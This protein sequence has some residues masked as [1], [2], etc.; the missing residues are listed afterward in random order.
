MLIREATKPH[1]I[2]YL[3]LVRRIR[4]IL[5]DMEQAAS[6]EITADA[7]TRLQDNAKNLLERTF[8]VPCVSESHD[9][10]NLRS[11]C[12][13]RDLDYK[14]ELQALF[15]KTNEESAKLK[16]LEEL[17]NTGNGYSGFI[18]DVIALGNLHQD[19]DLVAVFLKNLP[20][21][22]KQKFIAGIDGVEEGEVEKLSEGIVSIFNNE[23]RLIFASLT[24]EYKDPN[25]FP[26]LQLGHPY[27][28]LLLC[29]SSKL[30]EKSN[31]TF[32][33][34]LLIIYRSS[35][36]KEFKDKVWDLIKKQIEKNPSK[37]DKVRS[38]MENHIMSKVQSSEVGMRLK[39]LAM[40]NYVD[41]ARE[42][43]YK[44]Y[45]NCLGSKYPVVVCKAIDILS[46]GTYSEKGKRSLIE[47]VTKYSQSGN[48]LPLAQLSCMYNKDMGDKDKNKIYLELLEEMFSQENIDI[49]DFYKQI[50]KIKVYRI[51]KAEELSNILDSDIG[52]QI[53][54]AVGL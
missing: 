49:T 42:D 15:L 27:S 14:K 39:W 38:F 35:Y 21:D 45:S 50:E 19:Y 22:K 8:Q 13:E 41:I 29:L 51:F 48:Q 1:S 3:P 37:K 12:A 40:E 18:R 2:Q 20:T 7:L 30:N 16:I 24:E 54:E 31:K 6:D 23:P 5:A 34:Y 4:R 44:F 43:G 32:L 26:H 47:S 52:E 25:R 33:K 10:N 9:T 46:N 11:V 36:D 17:L 53:K 28:A